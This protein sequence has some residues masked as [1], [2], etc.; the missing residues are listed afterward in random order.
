M[1]HTARLVSLAALAGTILPPIL[2]FA[3]RMDI[4]S[5]KWAMLLAA[6]AWFAATPVWMDRR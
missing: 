5:M 2:F 1:R 4:D 6:V 3:G